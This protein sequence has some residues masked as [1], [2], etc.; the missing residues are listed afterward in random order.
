VKLMPPGHKGTKNE[1]EAF[2]FVYKKGVRCQRSGF[3]AAAG[4]KTAGQIEKE[5]LVLLSL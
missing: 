3:S 1:L 2:S 5:T 4:K